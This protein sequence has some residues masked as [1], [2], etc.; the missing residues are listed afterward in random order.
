M[1]VGTQDLKLVVVHS[2]HD[3]CQMLVRSDAVDEQ[4]TM[5]GL[6]PGHVGRVSVEIVEGNVVVTVA[7]ID[8]AFFGPVSMVVA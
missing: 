4:D 5:D 6:V 2:D 3:E 1:S 8:E 7:R